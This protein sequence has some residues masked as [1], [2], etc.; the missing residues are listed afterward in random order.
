M[1]FAAVF[2]VLA[3]LSLGTPALAQSG[4]ITGVVTASDGSGPVAGVQIVVSGARIGTITR[5]DGRYTLFV[6]P[7]TYTVKALRVGFAPDSATGVVVGENATV[8]ANLALRVIAAQLGGIVAVGYG[9][10]NERDRTNSAAVV[11]EKDFNTGRVVSVEQLITAK[12][13]GVQII[14]SNEPGGGISLRIRGASSVN[15][16]NEPLFVVDGQPITV[17]GGTSAGRN[18]LNFLNPADIA[19]ITV[20]KD[21]SA[22]SIYGSRGANGVVLIT[23]KQ[24]TQQRQITY[25]TT[26]SSSSVTR[27]PSLLNS[28]EFAAAV[29]Q[30]AP[31]N[32]GL[33]GGANTDFRDLVERR[34]AGVD[35]NLAVSGGRDDMRYRLSLNYL[36]QD[37]VILGTTAQRIA[38]T[39]N[40]SDR[41]LNER[42]EFR[43]NIRGSRSQD[44]FTPGGVIGSATAFAPT[45]PVRNADGTFF[46]FTN[47]LA[48]NNPLADLAQLSDQGV[49][50]RSLSN[51]EAKYSIP[52]ISGLSATVRSGFDYAQA[53]RT[54]FSPSTSQ[55][56]RETGR[57]GQFARNQP[58]SL[59]TSIEAFGSY[60]R[61]IESLKS[62]LE[63][64][65]GSSFEEFTNDSP[66]FVA[67]SLFT[68]L[69]GNGGLPAA[70]MPRN[71][72]NVQEARLAAQFGRVNYT[73]NDRYLFTGSIRRD[74]S[75]R[76][77][78]ANECGFFP[79]ASAAW[80]VIDE[81]FLKNLNTPLSDLKLRYSFGVSGN[82]PSGNGLFRSDFT[83]G[84]DRSQTQF[85]NDFVPTIRPSAVDPNLKW[86]ETT[87]NN[88]GL[89]YGLY[90]NRITGTVEYYTKK[91]DDLIFEVPVAGGT[92]LSNFVT[93]NIGKVENSGIEFAV[94]ARVLD[95]RDNGF[96]WDAQ[97]NASNNRNRLTEINA[98]SAGQRIPV[99]GIS[100]D[101]GSNIQVLQVGSPINS[102]NVF[103]SRRGADGQP[104]TGDLPDSA[105]FVDQNGDGNI[106]QDDRVAFNNAAP[107]W[108]IG[109]TSN[110]G[111][112]QFDL[113]LTVRAYLGNYV[114]NNVASNQGNFQRL[115]GPAPINLDRSVLRTGFVR[116]QLFSDI[117]VEDASFVRL[118]NLTLGYTRRKFVGVQS[119]RVFGTV[120]NLFTSTD[121]TGI[122]P[123]AGVNGIDNNIFPQARTFTVGFN[124]GF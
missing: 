63:V 73:Y 112:R 64:T 18:P 66:S 65:A 59:N 88:F 117:Y 118:D 55:V 34:A 108:I 114:Y 75:S 82:Q 90:N 77:G 67:D 27:G 43:A 53:S 74:C 25:G 54:F 86:E 80:R 12:V 92:N 101:I 111:F 57:G 50:F 87:S 51:V 102:F 7:G 116:P 4:R 2:T 123:T 68:D 47:N 35:H 70:G 33:L 5:D 83:V 110:V 119:L 6:N 109:H 76:F 98:A 10:T 30:F 94:S 56:D 100:G 29:A 19:S 48:P 104:V 58:S 20:L 45:Q 26:Y 72:F 91:T 13:P 124:V 78:P 36:D 61:R 28:T 81:S 113:S 121:Y 8:T 60:V 17:G 38:G 85:G 97:V 122:D 84:D 3:T 40:Y 96:T 103:R 52:R 106:N 32:V 23:T 105:L 99:G 24:G 39:L 69:L 115:R 71:F 41:L 46:Q 49:T 42:L 93:T 95:G 9:S 44:F 31:E 89:E 21:G 62:N 14:D 16:S 120:Q 22:A 37:G 11:Q 15:A 107:R 79:A 1:R